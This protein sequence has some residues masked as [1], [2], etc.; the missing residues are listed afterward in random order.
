[1]ACIRAII[2]RENNDTILRQGLITIMNTS[3]TPLDKTICE[4]NNIVLAPRDLAPIKILP[5]IQNNVSVFYGV[6]LDDARQNIEGSHDLFVHAI[7]QGKTHNKQIL[8]PY[9]F[10]F[11]AFIEFSPHFF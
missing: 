10:F 4:A 1:M 9:V 11:F 6:R 2:P 8:C 5:M 3:G 7:I